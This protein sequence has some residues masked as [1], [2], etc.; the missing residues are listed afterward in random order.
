MDNSGWYA[1]VSDYMMEKQ[2][3][4]FCSSQTFISHEAGDEFG[5]LCQPINAHQNG[6]EVMWKWQVSDEIHAPWWKSCWWYRKW[7][8]E[9]SRDCGGVLDP[10]ASV[11]LLNELADRL[12]EFGPP[13]SC[14]QWVCKLAWAQMCTS[15]SDVQLFHEELAKSMSLWDDKLRWCICINLSCK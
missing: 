3:C 10:F 6:V 4:N 7:L 11:T 8:H 2:M 13:N 14:Q 12:P 5:V 9:A 1:K 15:G